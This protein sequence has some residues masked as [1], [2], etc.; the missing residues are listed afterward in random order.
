MNSNPTRELRSFGL[1][2][3]G[4]FLVFFGLLFPIVLALDGRWRT[5]AIASVTAMAMAA[6]ITTNL[7]TSPK[8]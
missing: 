7:K 1:T 3:G 8:R 6:W 4:V 2:V 5:I